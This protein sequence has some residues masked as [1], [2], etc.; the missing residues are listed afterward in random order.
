MLAGLAAAACG[1]MK[2]DELVC[3]KECFPAA[4]APEA[5]GIGAPVAYWLPGAGASCSARVSVELRC[6][7]RVSW[8]GE[9]SALG[10]LL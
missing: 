2:E 3:I 1:G 7:E 4:A 8:F 9:K 6:F 5:P 10:Q